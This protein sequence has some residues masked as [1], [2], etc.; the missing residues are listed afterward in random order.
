MCV[1]VCVCSRLT[2]MHPAMHTQHRPGSLVLSSPL[3]YSDVASTILLAPRVW[4]IAGW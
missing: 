1:C 4:E 2:E 3:G